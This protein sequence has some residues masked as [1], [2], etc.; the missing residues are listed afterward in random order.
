MKTPAPKTLPQE[1][2]PH[3][4][5]TANNIVGLTLAEL[6]QLGYTITGK[7]AETGDL[8]H[9]VD[10]SWAVLGKRGAALVVAH[11]KT[12]DKKTSLVTRR[13]KC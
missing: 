3:A 1:L 10:G 12:R 13:K 5:A 8:L 7:S 6:E 11:N 2:V 9:L 4:K